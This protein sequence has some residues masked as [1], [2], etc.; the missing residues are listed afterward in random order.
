MNVEEQQGSDQ[1][2]FM[3]QRTKPL[4]RHVVDRNEARNITAFQD[5][6]AGG[7]A[8]S[9]GIV[10]G[11]PLDSIKVRMQMGTPVNTTVQLGGVA[12]LFRGIGAPFATAA[13]VNASIFCS[14]GKSTR[15]WDQYF[16]N[17]NEPASLKAFACGTFT[18]IVSS[19]LLCPTEHVKVQLQTQ[20]HTST[21]GGGGGVGTRRGVVYKDSFDATRK[22]VANHGIAGLYRGL[23]ATCCRQGPAF[24]IYFTSYGII[25]EWGQQQHVFGN[26]WTAC[27]FAGGTAGA[28]SWGVVYPF[29][30]LKSRIQ[31]LPLDASKKESSLE[32]TTRSVVK[33]GG[34]GA[35]YRGLGITLVRAFP[36][37]GIIFCVYEYSLTKLIGHDS[38]GEKHMTPEMV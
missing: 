6:M 29:D 8:G 25:K 34:W 9:A 3:V 18:G 13:L 1:V 5:L 2:A 32:H 28:I 31:A 21:S 15:L 35:L 37:N 26:E 11:F 17:K 12:S 14:Y 30:L 10:V 22:I 20:E 38:T 7:I 36:V 33:R 19:F 4:H 24:G 16:E 27:V 23:I